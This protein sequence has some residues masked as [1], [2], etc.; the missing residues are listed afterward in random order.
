MKSSEEIAFVVCIA[1]M[2]SIAAT[3]GY[4][5]CRISGALE[6]MHVL[7]SEMLESTDR[8]LEDM[9]EANET[10]ARMNEMEAF[11]AVSAEGCASP[12]LGPGS[13]N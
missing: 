9:R 11:P 1:G 8:M 10:L 13:D 12:D 5:G 6:R 7:T 4:Y 2:L 3:V